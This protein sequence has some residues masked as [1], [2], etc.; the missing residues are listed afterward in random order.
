MGGALGIATAARG[1][2]VAWV[3]PT[4]KNSRPL[5]R[6][7]EAAVKPV[8]RVAVNR[9]DRT[10]EFPGGG[11]LG[12]YTADND[13]SL[14]GE[15]FD[16]VIVDEAARIA[17]ETYSDVILPTLA[18]RDGRCLLISTPRGH[19]WFW[20]EWTKAQADG[21]RAQ[22]GKHRQARTRCRRFAGR[23]SWHGTGC[24]LA[25]TSRSGWRNSSRTAAGCSG[26]CERVRRLSRKRT[27]STG[28]NM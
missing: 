4:Y 9:A 21:V 19:D 10:V 1:H 14:R 24:H 17:E 15:A 5:W 28:T 12:V 27:P 22:P 13:V 3:A 23:R 20:R 2:A 16:F 8:K 6:F 26:A 7:I 18:D 11:W 25:R